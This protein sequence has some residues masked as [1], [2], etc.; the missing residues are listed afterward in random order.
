R[1]KKDFKPVNDQLLSLGASV[2]DAVGNAAKTP[3]AVLAG[4][5]DSFA[6][7][8]QAIKS[9]IDDL[10][11]PGDLKPQRTE[12]SSSVARL[13]LDLRNIAGSA[14]AHTPQAAR[15]ATASLINDSQAAGNA[16]RAL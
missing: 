3:D 4:E 13:I 2:G 14:K 7:R 15:A 12:L 5:F 1:F 16:R 10:D 8:L 6:V 9:R 11:P